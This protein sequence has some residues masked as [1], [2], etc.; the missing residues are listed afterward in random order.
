M[1]GVDITARDAALHGVQSNKALVALARA[2]LC[3]IDQT[4]A[5]DWGIDFRE[6]ATSVWNLL[7]KLGEETAVARMRALFDAV[8]SGQKREDIEFYNAMA[9]PSVLGPMTSKRRHL[10]IDVAACA[11]GIYRYLGLEGDI[12]DVG[13][14]AGTMSSLL[15]ELLGCQITGIDPAEEAIEQGRA[16]PARHANVF[17]EPGSMPWAT[18]RRFTMVVAASVMPWLPPRDLIF[19]KSLSDVLEPGGVAVIM[20][21]GWA[22]AAPDRLRRLLRAAGFGFGYADVAGGYGDIPAKFEAEGVVVLLK[23]GPREYPRKI[24]NVMESDWHIF[25]DYANAP[26]TPKREMT[27]AFE[28]SLRSVGAEEHA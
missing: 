25:R 16:H 3:R 9:H 1:A 18:D 6:G 7:Q 20:S 26:A 23:G 28:R 24:K 2:E 8:A 5:Q 27:Q 22:E 14:H 19:L 11:I 15:A 13:C 4:L 21:G 10:I 12:L 17:L